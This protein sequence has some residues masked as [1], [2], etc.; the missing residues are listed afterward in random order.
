[1]KKFC[2]ILIL[3]LSFMII[4][5]VYAKDNVFIESVSIDSKSE[6]TNVIEDAKYDGLSL[7][8]NVK[9]FELND[10]IKYKVVVN[11]PTNK[12]YEITKNSNFDD[13]KYI[14]YEYSYDDNDGG[15]VKKNSKMTMYITIKYNKEVPSNMFNNG[16]FTETNNL[17][18]D[19]GNNENNTIVNP[20]TSNYILIVLVLL[21]LVGT[22]IILFTPTINNESKYFSILIIGLLLPISIY[23]VEKLQI[24]IESNVVISN[25]PKFCY[26]YNGNSYY[27]EYEEG[28]TW[29]EYIDSDFNKGYIQLNRN[30]E[31]Q[32]AA[33]DN[34][35]CD[36]SLYFKNN[37]FFVGVRNE[38]ISSDVGCYNFSLDCDR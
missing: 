25:N 34:S 7:K 21:M 28:M 10:Y 6:G 35:E 16:T 38:I 4:P 37:M 27:Y 24:N 5:N 30:N 17:I 15:I 22:T 8:F 14:S 19:L 23:A 29:G 1:M 36:N 32:P 13:N 26:T 33:Y 11:N 3:F 12:D 31:A 18:I 20:K 9:F 2:L